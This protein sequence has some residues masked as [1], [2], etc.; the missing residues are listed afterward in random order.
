MAN[1]G[2]MYDVKNKLASLIS[3]ADA[4]LSPQTTHVLL[5]WK[6][7]ISKL[8]EAKF[9]VV[10]LRIMPSSTRDF[11]YG[12]QTESSERGVYIVYAFT[13]HIFAYHSSTGNAK[14]KAAQDLAD[15]I[16]SYL[17]Q[18]NKDDTTGIADIFGIV[19]RESEPSRGARRISRIIMNGY[20]LAK[21]PFA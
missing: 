20:I 9:P 7:D 8:T 16:E 2:Y 18:N 5:D 4:D 3:S 13:A 17:L 14:A 15:K 6:I 1:E 11:L 10:T 12:R 19:K 21:K